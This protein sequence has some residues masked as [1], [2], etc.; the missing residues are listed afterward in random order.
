M[1]QR[2][3]AARSRLGFPLREP[4]LGLH[5]QSQSFRI[6]RLRCPCEA[7][8]GRPAACNGFVHVSAIRERLA[9]RLHAIPRRLMNGANPGEQ[10]MQPR[11]HAAHEGRSLDILGNT[12]L[13]KAGS[14]D[15]D[16]AAAVFLQTVRP[17]GGP[18]A[19]VHA[20]T[21]EFF[22][23]LDG[24]IEAWIGDAHVVLT[25][26]MSATLPRGIPHR[27]DNCTNQPAR[28]LAIVTPGRG[29]R[30]FDDIDAARPQLP[31]ELDRLAAIVARHD[32]RFVDA[33]PA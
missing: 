13:E 25:A 20:D 8:T 3:E 32:I 19:H 16:G 9:A 22:Y 12:M 23:V 29:A 27:F 17:G 18:P 10:T 15:F 28:V 7:M 31:A 33:P 1:V 26:G 11:I 6:K 2:R 21:T 14:A 30:F 4:R 5:A 24:E